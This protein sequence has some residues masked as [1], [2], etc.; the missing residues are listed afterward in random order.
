MKNK[1]IVV[2][3]I[4]FILSISAASASDGNETYLAEADCDDESLSVNND[5]LALQSTS[6]QDN[7]TLTLTHNSQE[8][9][10]G[11]NVELDNDAD[12]ENINVGEYVTWIVTA[13]NF[14]PD[15]AKNVKVFDRLPDGLK[16]IRHSTTKGTFDPKT[17]IWDIGDLKTTDGEVSLLITTLAQS[18]GEKINKANLTCD[19]PNSSNKTYEEEEIDVFENHHKHNHQKAAKT[20][21]KHATGNP[22]ALILLSLF[23]MAAAFKSRL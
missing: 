13:K 5:S 12:P 8:N 14:G 23:G 9:L 18:I 15:T 2:L 6:P 20:N 21:S 7:E 22:I 19:T 10:S 16:Y 1:L 11:A 4:L 3:L 17:G